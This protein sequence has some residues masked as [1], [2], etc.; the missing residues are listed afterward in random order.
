[1]G[2]FLWCMNLSKVVILKREKEKGWTLGDAS[3]K[4]KSVGR[5][6]WKK[7]QRLVSSALVSLE[8][9]FPVEK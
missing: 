1:M 8:T 9:H 7:Q 2:E 3:F 5:G 4:H 6:L